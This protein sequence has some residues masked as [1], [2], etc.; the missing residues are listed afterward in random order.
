[1]CKLL[2]LYEY[3]DTAVCAWAGD[4]QALIYYFLT[5]AN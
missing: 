3:V 5:P 2:K 1:M 4:A